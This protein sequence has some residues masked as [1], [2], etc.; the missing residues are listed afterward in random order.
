MW[1]CFFI[2]LPPQ[3]CSF[4]PSRATGYLANFLE[5][6]SCILVPKVKAARMAPFSHLM[7]TYFTLQ[8]PIISVC[9]FQF[10]NPANHRFNHMLW[11]VCK[12]L[13]DFVFT[14]PWKCTCCFRSQCFIISLF[15]TFFIIINKLKLKFKSRWLIRSVRSWK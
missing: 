2:R 7:F 8:K 9:C 4:L 12:Y 13:C 1:R 6:E 5:W 11:G 10:K 14:R 15:Y 3:V